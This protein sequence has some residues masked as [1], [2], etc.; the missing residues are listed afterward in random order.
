[1]QVNNWFFGFGD[2]PAITDEYVQDVKRRYTGVFY[3]RMIEGKWVAAEGGV[4]T[5]FDPSFHVVDEH[6]E[7]KEYYLS[8]DWGFNNPMCLL[9]VGEDADGCYYIL[10]EFYQSGRLVDDH[11]NREL[12]ERGWDKL[13]PRKERPYQCL[14]D[15][16]SPSD[17]QRMRDMGWN[18]VPALKHPGSVVE[19]IKA[20]QQAFQKQENGRARLYFMR[21]CSKTIAEMSGYRWKTVRGVNKDEPVKENDHAVDAVKQFVYTKDAGRV[22]VLKSNPF[23]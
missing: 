8:C 3:Q 17:G 13:G 11:L 10:D 16:E 19:S 23:R 2:N 20:T 7:I 6:P 12:K 1:L 18:M 14:Y 15:V 9:L 22:K 5:N 21:H 4:F